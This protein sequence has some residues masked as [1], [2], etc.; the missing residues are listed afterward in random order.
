ERGVDVAIAQRQTQVLPLHRSQEF[1]TLPTRG[2]DVLE[3]SDVGCS[4]AAGDELNVVLQ[5][6]SIE[7]SG[8]LQIRGDLAACSGLE[9][10]RDHLLQRRIGKENVGQLARRF[11]SGTRELDGGGRPI[12]F[13]VSRIRGQRR[14]GIEVDADGGIEMYEGIGAVESWVFAAAVGD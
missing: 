3:V 13:V 9:G 6:G 4:T 14:R 10:L 5:I 7:R 12:A 11:R 2:T 8:P 1:G